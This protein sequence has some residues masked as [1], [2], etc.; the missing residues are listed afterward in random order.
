[1]LQQMGFQVLCASDGVEAVQVVSTNPA[2]VR[3]VLL[4]LTMPRMDGEETLHALRALQPDLP[5]I[6]TSGYNDPA[7]SDGTPPRGANGFI[8]KPYLFDQ[9]T[10][11][12]R[13][14]LSSKPSRSRKAEL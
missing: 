14:T 2:K 3:L 1:M 9:L 10:E 8:Q 7:A 13:K 11:V 5:I 6:L 4:D 12:V